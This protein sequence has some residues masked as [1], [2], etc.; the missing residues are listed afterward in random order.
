MK[1]IILFA[2][3]LLSM[4]NGM[5]YSAEEKV[6]GLEL[7]HLN[8]KKHKVEVKA[9]GTIKT[10]DS[11]DCSAR[12]VFD[13]NKKT[14]WC[15]STVVRE[16]EHSLI[17]TFYDEVYVERI[18]FVNGQCGE[19]YGAVKLLS[20]DRVI[21]YQDFWEFENGYRMKDGISSNTIEFLK[22][23]EASSV[24]D[25]FPVKSLV[26]DVSAV[27]PNNDGNA[28][29]ADIDIDLKRKPS[30][31]PKNMWKEVR[32][33]IFLNSNAQSVKGNDNF[34]VFN[35]E[36]EES[37]RNLNYEYFTELTYFAMKGNKEAINLFFS[38]NPYSEGQVGVMSDVFK[39]LMKEYLKAHKVHL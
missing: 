23:T 2:T 21:M 39:P 11:N 19:K 38:S 18:S 15:V 29:I 24:Y 16:N 33:Y 8:Y 27:Y 7:F 14:T 32:N 3:Y 10:V 31:K 25:L 35:V 12:N 26:I 30:F 36:A 17:V 6:V 4:L 5:A 13:S 37:K 9:L 34:W 1:G 20:V 28:C 22:D